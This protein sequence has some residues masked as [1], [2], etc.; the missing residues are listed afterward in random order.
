MEV[1]L[2]PKLTNDIFG[3]N[4]KA[5]SLSLPQMCCAFCFSV[6][7]M[8]VNSKVVL[9]NRSNW[10][11][12]LVGCTYITDDNSKQKQSRTTAILKF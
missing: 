6:W 4:L 5:V 7:F 12:T 10:V 3:S 11:S 2:K 8:I 9:I 1:K